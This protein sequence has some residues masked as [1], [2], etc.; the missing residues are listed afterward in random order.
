MDRRM[1]VLKL[2][3]V[4]AVI[5]ALAAPVA[6][7]AGG[8]PP[9]QASSVKTTLKQIKK[10]KA[11]T[12]ALAKELAALQGK[13]AELEG[14]PQAVNSIPS[15]PA[16]GDLTGT[17]PNPLLRPNTI[18]SANVL[19]GSLSG[20]D[21]AADAV[22][23][24]NIADQSVGSTDFADHTIG[25][26][27]L[28]NASVGGRQIAPVHVVEGPSE[29]VSPGALVGTNAAC[30]PTERMIAGGSEWISPTQAFPNLLHIPKSAPDPGNSN[31]WDAFGFN[32]TNE[33]ADEVT[34]HFRAV[35]LCLKVS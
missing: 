23:S 19:D 8:G 12:T 31:Q 4:A 14:R 10:L 17:Y 3:I 9:A 21:F 16:G 26:V 27:D 15:G 20:S 32:E 13:A 29:K 24:G 35:A 18:F 33:A 34:M 5:A 2:V 22:Q 11:R 6:V 25:R 28:S 7:A 1:G 30:G